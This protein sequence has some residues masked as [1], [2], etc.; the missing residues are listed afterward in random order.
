MKPL[1]FDIP[2]YHSEGTWDKACRGVQKAGG[3]LV[4]CDILTH[5][6]TQRVQF[7]VRFFGEHGGEVEVKRPVD[8]STLDIEDWFFQMALDVRP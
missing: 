2:I 5:G 8:E 1:G 6:P 4:K 7:T 3:V